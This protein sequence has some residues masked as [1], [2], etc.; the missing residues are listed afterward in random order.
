MLE[1]FLKGVMNFTENLTPRKRKRE[2][3][4]EKEEVFYEGC[5]YQDEKGKFHSTVKK[6]EKPPDSKTEDFEWVWWELA[7]E[8]RGKWIQMYNDVFEEE[9]PNFSKTYS[10]IKN[11]FN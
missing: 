3:E 6:L 9:K 1:G 2:K 4:E 7:E 5:Y 11:Y 8:G 10:K